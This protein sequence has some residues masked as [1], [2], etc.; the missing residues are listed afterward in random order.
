MTKSSMSLRSVESVSR[1]EGAFEDKVHSGHI[2]GCTSQQTKH[3]QRRC[4]FDS[5]G[6]SR[7]SISDFGERVAIYKYGDREKTPFLVP[8]FVYAPRL[9]RQPDLSR[10]FYQNIFFYMWIYIST[11]HDD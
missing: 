1:G 2:C 10:N 9:A 8:V 5:I 4:E 7:L 11:V 6:S 3:F